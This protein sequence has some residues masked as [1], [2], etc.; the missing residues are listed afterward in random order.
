MAADTNVNTRNDFPPESMSYCGDCMCA[1]M[2]A[3][4]RYVPELEEK[5]ERKKQGVFLF[6]GGDPVLFVVTRGKW[7]EGVENREK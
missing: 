4:Y 5:K 3:Q 1:C 7:G 2:Y 6:R